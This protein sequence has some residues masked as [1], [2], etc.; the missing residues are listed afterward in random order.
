MPVAITYGRAEIGIDAPLVTV[1]ADTSSGGL[2]QIV[3]VGL[4]ET[5]V[6]ESKDR[7]KA[8]I[9]NSGFS[10]PSR[11]VTV[12][13][14]PADL[15]KNGG[16]YDLA[17]AL[18]ILAASKQL[19]PD[20]LVGH[21]FLGELALDGEIRSV[22]GVLP[23]A[24]QGA[25]STRTLV[26]PSAN[27]AEAS[28]SRGENILTAQN[29]VQVTDYLKGNSRLPQ[30]SP[31]E[32]KPAAPG[33]L[34]LSDIRGQ[35]AAKRALIIAAAGAH[36]LVFIGPPGSGKTMLASRLADLLPPMSLQESL[37]VASIRSVSKYA[38]DI[39]DWGRRP[40]RTPHHT[41]SAVALVGGSS[42]PKPG[43]ISLAHQGVLFLDEL[44]E[45]TRHVLEVLREP[46]E[47]GR[48]IIS[49]ATQQVCFPAKFQL[50][51][52]MNPCPCGYHG[53]DSDRCTCTNDR[54]EKYRGRVSGP[55][56]DRIDLH[57][58]VPALPGGT[59]SDPK[60]KGN[61]SEHSEA[62]SNVERAREIMFFRGSSLNAHLGGKEMEEHC[63][64]SATDSKFLDRAM[65]TLGLSARGYYKVL[66][67]AR[68][69]ADIDGKQ[70]IETGH[71][72]EALS[73][74]GLDRSTTI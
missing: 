52:A 69:I 70:E 28:L 33:K 1:E 74:R 11:R 24:I 26:V 13:L 19:P 12:N 23:A 64:L 10:V 18:A 35:Y 60:Y 73:Y 17:I 68:T 62:I 45:Y 34:K 5:A 56:M 57:V 61:E 42:P 3:I 36:N 29:M 46:L 25:R 31:G 38:F 4:P 2:P 55:L 21:E 14:A 72:T 30:P 6:K 7:V 43:E 58:D 51:A 47:S 65:E 27:S 40:F 54:V 22:K 49:R 59:L 48:I 53:D 66:K 44:P 15:P 71:L 41:A 32:W 67:V 9:V 16:R 37:E 8:A 20:S 39:R 63:R 50:V